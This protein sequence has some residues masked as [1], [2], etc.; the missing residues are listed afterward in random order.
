MLLRNVAPA[1]PEAVLAAF[2]RA[3][4]AALC[5]RVEFARLLRSFA[6]DPALFDRSTKVMAAIAEADPEDR[7]QAAAFFEG[8]FFL[9]LSGT[10]APVQQRLA[11]VDT[12]FGP[13]ANGA[14][15]WG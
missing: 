9:I 12:Q 5:G 14:N 1:A 10:H 6:W 11:A 15:P 13:A 8:L 2:E 7:S 3:S 4:P